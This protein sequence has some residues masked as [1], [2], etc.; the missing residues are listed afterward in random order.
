MARLVFLDKYICHCPSALAFCS[1]C[2]SSAYAALHLA[3]NLLFNPAGVAFVFQLSLHGAE[4][5]V[6]HFGASAYTCLLPSVLCRLFHQFRILCSF[7]WTISLFLCCLD[8]GF[9]SNVQFQAPTQLKELQI[10]DT[11]LEEFSD[12]SGVS[13]SLEKITIDVCKRLQTLLGLSVHRK[14][15]ELIISNCSELQELS[16]VHLSCV[17]KLVLHNC[18]SL[19]TVST[20]NVI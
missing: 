4:P 20:F 15:I 11:Y 18:E 10:Q 12:L 19:K 17:E 16:V 1:L 14:L 13:N 9:L 3:L 2:S 6:M 8:L 5:T 7:H